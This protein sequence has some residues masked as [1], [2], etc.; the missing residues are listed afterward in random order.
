M[1]RAVD[2]GGRAFAGRPVCTE[3]LHAA[4]LDN[5]GASTAN[6]QARNHQLRQ[7][8]QEALDAL[9]ASRDAYC[10]NSLRRKTDK[11]SVVLANL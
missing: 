7:R 10:G 4:C 3:V 5:V 8:A 6:H 9:K 1:C 11:Q 2:S